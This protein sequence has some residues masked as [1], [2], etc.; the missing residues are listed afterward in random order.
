VI[1]SSPTDVQPVFNA[2]AR[3]AM[4]LCSASYGVVTRYEG[5]LVHLVS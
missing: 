5:G 4:R 2:I 3:E 1:S